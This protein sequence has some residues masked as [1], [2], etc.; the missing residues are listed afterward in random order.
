MW[1]ETDP[2]PLDQLLQSSYCQWNQ[3]H[4]YANVYPTSKYHQVINKVRRSTLYDNTTHCCN[5]TQDNNAI[6]KL[7][8][9]KQR[10]KLLYFI[11]KKIQSM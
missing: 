9:N 3:H 11:L 7:N 10:T 6:K 1:D 2:P 4:F 8:N 5:D